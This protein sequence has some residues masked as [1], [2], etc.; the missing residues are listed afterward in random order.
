MGRILVGDD[1]R[2]MQDFLEILLARDGHEVVTVGSAPQAIAAV[3]GDEFDLVIS[4]IRMPE[5]SGLELLGRIEELSPET[6]VV[7]ITAHGSTET[8]VEAMKQGAYDYVVKPF[9]VDELK[10]ILQKAFEK[11]AMHEEN[12][13]LKEL[14]RTPLFLVYFWRCQCCLQSF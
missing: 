8:A 11:R 3:E 9:N 6:P 4:D 14:L 7:M 10:L 12:R 5:M 2:S 1:E 13:N